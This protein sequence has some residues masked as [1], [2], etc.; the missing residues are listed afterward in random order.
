VSRKRRVAVLGATGTVGQ[1]FI[2]LLVGHP[3]FEISALTT[4]ERN[5]GKRYGDVAH[6]LVPGGVPEAVADVKLEPTRSE[7]DADICFSALPPDAASEAEA[8][9][10]KA[11]HHVFSNVKT[12]R[13]DE[14]V[15]LIIAEVNPEHAKALEVQRRRRGWNGSIVTNG[16]C[17]AI[18][19]ALA[20]APLHKSF[21]IERV[22]VTTLQALSG[23]SYPGVASLDAL[24]NVVP[25]IAEEEEKMEQETK[26]FLGAWNGQRFVPAE[27]VFS[28]HCN[29]VSVRDGHTDTVSMSLRGSPSVAEV[30]ERM[31]EFRGRPQ[32][33]A[34][35]T[36][37][38]RPVIVREERDRPQPLIDRDVEGGMAAV[39]GRV[40]EDAVLG[41]R[42]VVLTHNTI[43][44]AAGASVLNAEL[45]QA[46]GCLP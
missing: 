40:Q 38:K 43:R 16:N 26:K 29:R 24:D 13:M 11:G 5:V 20:A 36:A 27:F 21:G 28:A 6:W 30:K 42:Y 9:L 19:F 3:W 12:H 32:E 45:L 1:R 23:A 37:P 39:V 17:S 15:P 25:F 22:V 34:L 33:L 35:P 4:S 7:L 31:R 2:S 41:I 8:A 18:G 14:D 46:E 10:A 44:G